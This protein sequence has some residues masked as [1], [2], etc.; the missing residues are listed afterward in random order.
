VGRAPT[1]QKPW[2]HGKGRTGMRSLYKAHLRVTLGHTA[3][4]P[5]ARFARPLL[6]R[7]PPKRAAM[8][9]KARAAAA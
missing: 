8:A 1:Q 6:E 2:F 3:A 4:P 7:A 5:I 9:P